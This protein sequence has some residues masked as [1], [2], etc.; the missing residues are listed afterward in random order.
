METV[1]GLYTNFKDKFKDKLNNVVDY[2]GIILNF[3]MV[4]CMLSGFFANNEI[5]F[6]A[7]QFGSICFIDTAACKFGFEMIVVLTR[8][9]PIL[10]LFG[11]TLISI[12]YQ[13]G[14]ATSIVL[15][16]AL[17]S[18][19]S[20]A[21]L[22]FFRFRYRRASFGDRCCVVV[23]VV[24]TTLALVTTICSIVY[25][26]N[27]DWYARNILMGISVFKR[28]QKMSLEHMSD[29]WTNFIYGIRVNKQS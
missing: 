2:P 12:N 7:F 18:K 20:I 5:L 23:T 22:I 15:I 24:V 9:P 21:H 28:V 8:M 10:L 17:I 3:L 4:L 26:N 19:L 1:S 25:E 14:V 27:Y 16:M 6:L 29:F 13:E 11:S